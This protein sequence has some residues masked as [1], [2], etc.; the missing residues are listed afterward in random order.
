LIKRFWG[1]FKGFLIL[2][3][4][5]FGALVVVISS[6]K[7]GIPL[8]CPFKKIT[9]IPCPGCGGTRS[10]LM[11]LNG[12]VKGALLTNP[13][14]VVFIMSIFLSLVWLF[15]DGVKGTNSYE[16]H[17]LRKWNTKV[18]ILVIAVIIANWMWSIAKGL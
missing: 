13:I 1:R 7:F 10:T 14:S 17:I 3:W 2:S 16:K 11:L 18:V 6:Q 15:V 9:G 12:D 8:V 5:C 4:I